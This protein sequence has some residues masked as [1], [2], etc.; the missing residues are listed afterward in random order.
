MTTTRTVAGL[1]L[2]MIVS[3][4][5]GQALAQSPPL[6]RSTQGVPSPIQPAQVQPGPA[7]QVRPGGQDERLRPLAPPSTLPVLSFEQ[8]DLRCARSLTSATTQV[9]AQLGIA[10]GATTSGQV[11]VDVRIDGVSTGARNVRVTNGT[12][13]VTRRL[14]LAGASGEHQVEFVLDGRVASEPQRFSHSCV[15]TGQTRADAPG[16]LTLPNLA[17][18]NLVYA[19]I[20]PPPPQP[21]SSGGGLIEPRVSLGTLRVLADPVIV[22][23]AQSTTGRLQFPSNAQCPDER[24]AYAT[25]YMAIAISTQRVSDPAAYVQ[26]QAGPFETEVN[27]V[28]T[29]DGPRLANGDPVT[30][31]GI[32]GTPLPQGYQWI[33]IKPALPCTR[34]GVLEVRFDPSNRLR[35]SNEADNVLRLRYSTVPR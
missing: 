27:F 6:P 33:V 19:E 10:P 22:R 28:D 15:R 31:E 17:F 16:H 12:A 25:A 2:A 5:A 3:M 13:S 32:T 35:E 24:D 20:L 9:T 34:D 26:V 1:A 14:N 29:M 4:M 30:T 21:R 8:W 11:S 18:G 7:T 23:D